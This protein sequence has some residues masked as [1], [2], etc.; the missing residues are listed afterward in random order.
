MWHDG[1]FTYLR[2]R[3]QESPALYELRDGEPALVAYD[4]S[5]DG[6]YI[7]R[8]VLADGWLQI[9]D[10]RA[11]WRFTPQGRPQ[12]SRWKQWVSAARKARCRA[13]SSRRR[14]SC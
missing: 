8:H 1:Q 14:A 13:A 5:E 2:S 11:A 4:L 3:A 12:M 7:A 10:K 6:L 9:G